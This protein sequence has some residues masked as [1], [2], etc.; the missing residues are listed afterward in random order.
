M[1]KSTFFKF[2][3]GAFL[4][5]GVLPSNAATLVVSNNNDTGAGSLRN[6]VSIANSG[7]TL[8]FTASTNNTPIILTIGQIT[9]NKNLII[10]GNGGTNT[11][12][13]ANNGGP[14]LTHRLQCLSPAINAGDPS[15][16]DNDQ[17]GLSIYLNRRD[18]GS[19]ERQD[20]CLTSS[21]F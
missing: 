6:A 4:L 12:I 21:V 17:R 19:F 15:I 10:S 20:S 14:T 18:M 5:G 16:T 8:L 3:Y 11:I 9:I 1:K 13:D 7:D 2:L